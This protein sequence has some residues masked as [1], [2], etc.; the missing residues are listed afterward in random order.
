M[1]SE[2]GKIANKRRFNKKKVKAWVMDIRAAAAFVMLMKIHK[3]K[4]HKTKQKS[5]KLSLFVIITCVRYRFGLTLITRVHP[6]ETV[7]LISELRYNRHLLWQL[8]GS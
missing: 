7:D 4:R 8:K 1:A 3:E 6:F 5:I 2:N